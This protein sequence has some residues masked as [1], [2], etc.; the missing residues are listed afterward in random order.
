M[1]NK[2][3]L[4]NIYL[5]VIMAL[6]YL[7]ILLVIIYSFNESK[8]SS[9]W[10]GL[11]LKWYKELFRDRALIE[12]LVNSLILASLSSLAAAVIGTLGAVGMSRSKL[13]IN[14]VAE[15]ISTLP[16]MIPEIILG[17]V[18]LIFFSLLGLPF[19]MTTLVIA[20]TAFCIPYVFLLV[21]A[22]LAGMDK[23]LTE[24]ARDLGASGFR[25]FLDITLPLILPA[26]ASGILLS[27]AMS[28][29]DVVI[30][31]FVTGVNTN[32][33]PI[34]IYTQLKTGVTPKINALCTLLFLLTLVLGLLSLRLGSIK[35]KNK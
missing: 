32:T 3:K 34:K 20:H 24:A 29:D 23:S 21:K 16:I 12:A 19:G 22:R 6:M 11:S 27:F 14:S 17:I 8:I 9:V 4:P 18:F 10:S 1:K 25:A 2:T 26:I 33:L 30:S 13:K 35:N 15:Y 7:P 5:A 31:I 28:L